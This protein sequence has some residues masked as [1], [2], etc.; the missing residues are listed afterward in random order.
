MLR[1]MFSRGL[2]I[3]FFR[4]MEWADA[5]MWSAV[6]GDG[7]PDER[8]RHLLVHIH[9]VQRSFLAA[10]RGTDV[11]AVYRRAE[12]FG[13]LR[14]VRTW[15]QPWYRDAR[16]FVE[17][18][19]DEELAGRRAMPWAAQV[20]E[21]LGRPAGETTLGETCFQLT[22]HTTHHRGQV[23]ARVRELGGE[24]PIVDYIA[25]LW[26]ERPAPEWPS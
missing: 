20:A 13:T 10:W 21:Y 9:V 6:P 3:E 16:A 12:D 11:S 4:H 8:L 2:L 18:S 23:G 19:S 22:S 25:W 15:A 1:N 14:D 17:G 5:R 7:T 26:L 24:P